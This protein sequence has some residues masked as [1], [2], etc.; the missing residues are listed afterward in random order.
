MKRVVVVGG[1]IAGATA[2]LRLAQGGASVTLLERSTRLGGLVVSFELA[3]TPLE[4]FYHHVFPHETEIQELITE[5]GLADRLAWLPSSVGIYTAGRVWPF[6]SAL[7]LL[8]FGPLPPLDRVRAG[9]GALRLRR[10]SEWEPL[11]RVRAVDWLE[12]L[13]GRRV[14]D[15]VWRPL[16]HQ[17][18]G[19][20]ADDVPAAW[21]WGRLQQRSGGRRAGR[22]RLGYLRGG[23]RQ[24]FDA[25]ERRL[26]DLGVDL[27]MESP[28]RRIV[29]DDRVEGVEL[30]DGEIVAADAAVYAG[31]QSGLAGLVPAPFVDPRWSAVD[32]LGAVC[33]V[34]QLA[35]PLQ[36]LYWVNVCDESLPFGG[37]IE[38]TN[39][40]PSADYAGSHVVYLSR[41]FTQDEPLATVDL[42]AESS[43]WVSLLGDRFPGV[44]DSLVQVHPFRTR[45]AAPLVF[46]GYRDTLAPERAAM[47]GLYSC[48]TAQIYPQDRG[49][50]EGVKRATAV[51]ASVLADAQ[52]LPV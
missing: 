24:L 26:R 36:D 52:V 21:M 18:F 33:V 40:V 16:L 11:D 2:A 17:K 6:T 20:A 49:M 39:L 14:T 7:D 28:V 27:R 23:F 32:D 50:S 46:T 51:A 19:T 42:E 44:R 35:R 9:V 4:C 29:G 47:P 1:G 31:T 22:E 12:A 45:A 48:T 25:M 15:T 10:A 13:T 38:H 37:I 8:R 5:L 3:G 34:L 43:R 30:G 41:Y